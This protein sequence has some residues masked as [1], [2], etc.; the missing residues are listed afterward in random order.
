MI[1]VDASV[2]ATALVDAGAGG[3]RARARL[4][5]EKIA[6][7]ELVDL[8]IVSVLRGLVRSGQIETTRAELALLDLEELRLDRASHAPLLPR[9][10]ELRHNLT[11]Y[12][13]AYV[14]LAEHLDCALVTADVSL[15]RSNG[16]QCTFEVLDGSDDVGG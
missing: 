2:L 15:S 7:P 13:G 8:E 16:P 9:V 4:S 6:A 5:G 12:D 1:V 10:W 3:K 11:P 14:A